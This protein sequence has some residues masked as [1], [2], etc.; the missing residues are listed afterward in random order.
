MRF[1]TKFCWKEILKI[2]GSDYNDWLEAN[3]QIDKKLVN[4]HYCIEMIKS[5]P[6]REKIEL[7]FL[8]DKEINHE[9]KSKL[10][11]QLSNKFL[12]KLDLINPLY[13]RAVH[14]LRFLKDAF[15]ARKDVIASFQSKLSDFILYII[16]KSD[17]LI[18]KKLAVETVGLVDENK[19]DSILIKAFLFG[20]TWISETA[21][22]SCRH[23]HTISKKLEDRILS[24]IKALDFKS[25]F[26]R[27]KKFLFSLGLS[28]AFKSLKKYVIFKILYFYS[29]CLSST[30]LLISSLIGIYLMYEKNDFSN[31]RIYIVFI[32]PFITAFIS[33]FTSKPKILS[34]TIPICLRFFI[35]MFIL[36]ILVKSFPNLDSL[37][38]VF[39]D[40]RQVI[41]CLLLSLS[42][43]PLFPWHFLTE[44]KDFFKKENWI[45]IPILVTTISGSY[46]MLKYLNIYSLI[47]FISI[48][49]I[50]G[51]YGFVKEH[52]SKVIEKFYY[53]FEF[54]KLKKIPLV[55]VH[56][57][58]EIY[59]I[60]F[61]FRSSKIRLSYIQRL[62]IND[63]KI[64]GNWPDGKLPNINNDE[65][66]TL[67]A[68]LEEK[69]LGLD[70]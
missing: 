23:L 36:F 13:L 17:N 59:R 16:E 10:K 46:F 7:W 55:P 61:S 56:R 27:R 8:D 62:Q 33:L 6:V 14:S 1:Y 11:E 21:F 25:F 58:E 50:F 47:V 41:L 12:L 69:W 18:I 38:S 9:L 43:L 52:S 54:L 67:I 30:L 65:S 19:L 66:S 20:N 48:A 22:N 26:K 39:S 5:L 4:K 28:D 31:V 3:Q 57:R 29:F 49:S 63:L 64:E 37:A 15:R 34:E 42:I 44:M 51:I 35:P 2:V 68:K 45:V 53:L 60:F 32:L 24:Y 40:Y 70:R